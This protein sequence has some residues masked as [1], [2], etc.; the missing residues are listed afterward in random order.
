MKETYKNSSIVLPTL[1]KIRVGTGD[2]HL[3]VKQTK[4]IF[5]I[6]IYILINRRH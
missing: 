4:R 2:F 5:D 6:Y 1:T 3:C